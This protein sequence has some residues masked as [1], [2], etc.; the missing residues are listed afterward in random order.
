MPRK[1]AKS[2]KRFTR[3]KRTFKRYNKYRRT[4]YR[5][6]ARRI[7]AVSKRVAGEVCKFEITPD[8][9]S[10]TL[11][12]PG[13]GSV[14]SYT[15]STVNTLTTITS[16]EPWIMPLN[17]TYSRVVSTSTANTTPP[18]YN[19]VQQGIPASP[20]SVSFRQPIWYNTMPGSQ[21]APD[22]SAE[23]QYRLKY[24]YIN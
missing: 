2:T 24:I 17:W 6:L 18:Y 3:T 8:L 5:I 4:G 9:F 23:L 16:G 19:G 15:P 10:N 22:V 13:T 11:L 21:E 7:N 12:T 20:V 14:P 1:Y